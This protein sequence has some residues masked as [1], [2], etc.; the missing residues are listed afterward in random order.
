MTMCTHARH[1]HSIFCILPPEILESIAS[2]GSQAQRDA[3]LQTLS[4]DNTVRTLRAIRLAAPV[5]PRAVLAATPGSPQRTIY[6]AKNDTSLPGKVVRNEGGGPTGDV[7]ADEAYDALGD[8]YNLYWNAFTRNSIDD[9]GLPLDATVHYDTNY[10]NAYWDGT[11]MVFGDGDGQLFNRFTIAKDIIGHEL[12]HGVTEAEAQ[13]YY[14]T[15]S[16]ALNESVSDVFGS[17]VKQ[18]V[19][20]QDAKSADWLIGEGL[21]TSAVNGQALRS[22]KAPGTAYNDP[23][24]GKDPQ[25]DHMNKFV[26]TTRD[27]GG[28]HINSGIPNKAFYEVAVALGGKAWEKAGRIWY[29]TLRDNQLKPDATFEQFARLTAANARRLYGVG[30]TEEK[31][32]KDAWKS[33]GINLL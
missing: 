8:T 13:L 32:V 3:A 22:M 2:R 1:R 18:Y 12:T 26:V 15:Q 28:V 27:N 19:N 16:G 21:F 23:V 14:F 4:T 5:V 33:V 7:A 17:L 10:D 25:P 6:D 20:N 9:Q 29:D 31:V 11:R 30:S 24:L